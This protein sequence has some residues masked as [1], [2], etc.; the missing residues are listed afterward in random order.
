MRISDWSSDVCSS[1]LDLSGIDD[2]LNRWRILD[3]D[4]AAMDGVNPVYIPRNHLVEEA[5]DAA[6]TGDLGP[7][8]QLLD[9]V[10]HPFDQR[11]G[12]ERFEAPA[13]AEFGRYT[14][15]CGTCVDL[16]GLSG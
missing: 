13:P 16:R 4:S 8:H 10:Q 5:L 12:L 7:V 1:D 6:T 2:W 14:T 9:V 11:S 3:P 15:Y